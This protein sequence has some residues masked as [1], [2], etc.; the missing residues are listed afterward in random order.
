[1]SKGLGV[2]GGGNSPFKIKLTKK[3]TQIN[4]FCQK[5]VLEYVPHLL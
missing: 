1:M 5:S 3:G 2:G 4:S